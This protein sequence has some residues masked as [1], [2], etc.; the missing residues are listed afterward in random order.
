MVSAKNCSPMPC[1]KCISC[2]LMLP[3]VFV[4]V[5]FN[6]FGS[7]KEDTWLKVYTVDSPKFCFGKANIKFR[8]LF[9]RRLELGF[10]LNSSTICSMIL[11]FNPISPGKSA[12]AGLRSS[13]SHLDDRSRQLAA[14]RYRGTY[15]FESVKFFISPRQYR[16]GAERGPL[17][18]L[19]IV[20]PLHVTC[21][22]SIQLRNWSHVIISIPL[23]QI[24]VNSIMGI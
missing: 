2:I 18:V 11:Q 17:K 13:S 5:N 9:D 4:N 12:T 15:F 23:F 24:I 7:L 10:W 21:E 16:D 20:P 8:V 3:C 19:Q 6:T 14:V 22:N 1:A